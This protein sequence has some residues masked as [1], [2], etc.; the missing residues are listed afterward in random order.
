M[1]IGLSIDTH[2]KQTRDLI[3]HIVDPQMAN[4]SD[5]DCFSQVIFEDIELYKKMKDDPWYRP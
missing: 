1:L 3:S 5:Y 4:V 2:P